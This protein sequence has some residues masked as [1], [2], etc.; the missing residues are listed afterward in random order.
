MKI[1]LIRQRNET[2]AR[3]W[4]LEESDQSQLANAVFKKKLRASSFK[5]QAIGK[6]VKKIFSTIIVQEWP[7]P[8]SRKTRTEGVKKSKLFDPAD[9]GEFFDFSLPT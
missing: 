7:K 9:G 6:T 8:V 3:S 4:K 2:E 5:L 1:R